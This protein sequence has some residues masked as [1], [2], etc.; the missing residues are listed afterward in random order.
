MQAGYRK[1]I[2]RCCLQ[3]CKP[4]PSSK[5]AKK[6]A[7]NYSIRQKRAKENNM[8]CNNPGPRSERLI[9]GGGIF[10]VRIPH[11]TASDLRAVVQIQ[12]IG[13]ILPNG[14][15]LILHRKKA[16]LFS[17]TSQANP[18]HIT[19]TCHHF[20]NLT[21]R[22]LPFAQGI[23]PGINRSNKSSHHTIQ[24]SRYKNTAT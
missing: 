6:R 9:L 13:C 3:I 17:S 22:T 10:A 2:T 19:F 20:P 11:T 5:E 16:L 18:N 23:F 12:H 7:D 8:P 14:L 1:R 15:H 21:S 24:K 4:N